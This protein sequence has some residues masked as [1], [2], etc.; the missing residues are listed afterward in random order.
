MQ[1]T[2]HEFNEVYRFKDE[3]MQ[4]ECWLCGKKTPFLAGPDHSPRDG[5]ANYVCMEHLDNDAIIK[6]AVE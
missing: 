1:E 3:V 6:E 2:K 5:T 4:G